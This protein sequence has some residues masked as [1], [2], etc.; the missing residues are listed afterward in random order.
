MGNNGHTMENHSDI[1]GQNIITRGHCN[2]TKMICDDTLVY[3]EDRIWHCDD[4]INHM[5][6]PIV[7]SKTVCSHDITLYGLY[8]LWW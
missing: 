6:G 5:D 7:Y 8:W 3:N 2:D 4:T 1:I